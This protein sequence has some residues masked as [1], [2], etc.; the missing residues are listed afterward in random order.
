VLV[1]KIIDPNVD[2][3]LTAPAQYISGA[4]TLDDCGRFIVKWGRNA[5]VSGG[6]KGLKSVESK[7][8]PALKAAGV[9]CEVNRFTG[10]C[11]DKNIEA[12]VE[13]VRRMALDAIIGVGGG[14]SLDAAKRAAEIC[15]VP[16]ICIPTIAATCAAASVLAVIYTEEGVHKKDHYLGKNPDLV[17][18]DTKVIANAPVEYFESGILDSLSKWYEGKAA[19]KGVSDPDLFTLA[20]LKLAELL[21]EIMEREAVNAIQAVKRGQATRAVTQVADLNIYMAA[22]IQSIGKRTRGAAAHAIHAGLS[23]IPQ[24]HAILHGY[25]VG[26]GIVALLFMEKAGLAEIERVVKFFRQLDL[27]PSFKGLGLPYEAAL[28]REVAEKS[29]LCDPMKNMPFEVRVEHV[30]AAMEQVEKYGCKCRNRG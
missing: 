22:V 10:E 8:F 26:Y 6:N 11:S 25:K 13:K 12:L 21:N 16:V 9:K 19:F 30:V 17:L 18:V 4:N 27:D 28:L 7:L 15:N 29:I 24:S 14:K 2:Y 5:L 3:L 20:A 23:V 1:L